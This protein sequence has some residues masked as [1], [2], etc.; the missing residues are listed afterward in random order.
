[1]RYLNF[2]FVRWRLL[3]AASK[4][5]YLKASDSSNFS[6]R[7]ADIQPYLQ[8]HRVVLSA[9]FWNKKTAKLEAYIWSGRSTK[10]E[11]ILSRNHEFKTLFPKRASLQKRLSK[12]SIN[13]AELDTFT[14]FLYNSPPPPQKKNTR[15]GGQGRR[16]LSPL[17]PTLKGD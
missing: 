17:P 4:V 12:L 16:H 11:T 10:W 13:S 9:A 2:V 7:H 8:T 3:L 5:I 1:M 14:N 6:L 15:G